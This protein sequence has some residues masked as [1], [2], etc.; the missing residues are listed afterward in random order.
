M[1]EGDRHRLNRVL[2]DLRP[3]LRKGG[4][5]TPTDF[6]WQELSWKGGYVFGLFP[7]EL[8]DITN[9]WV[10]VLAAGEKWGVDI[11]LGNYSEDNIPCLVFSLRQVEEAR[12][13]R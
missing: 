5:S 3:L 8:P 10:T 4:F 7:E 12:K 1:K 13:T 2:D 11:E 6:A 9:G